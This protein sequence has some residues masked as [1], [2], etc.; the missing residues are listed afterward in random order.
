MNLK[1]QYLWGLV[2]AL[3]AL[4]Y[5]VYMFVYITDAKKCDKYMKKKDVQFRKV[6]WWVTLFTM[7]LSFFGVLGMLITIIAGDR[8]AMQQYAYSN[9]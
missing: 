1:A 3:I 2:S 7:I 5:T 6:A 9:L 4:A 8:G